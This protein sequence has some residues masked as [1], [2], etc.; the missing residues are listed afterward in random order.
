VGN[1]CESATFSSTCF[2]EVLLRA[3]NKGALGYIGGTNNTYWNEDFWWGVGV[4]PISATPTYNSTNLGAYDRKFHDM[5]GISRQDWYVAQGAMTVAGNL[6]VAQSGSSRTNYYWEIYTLLGDP[7]LVVWL[8]Q[9]DT[10][11]LTYSDPVQGDTELLVSTVSDALVAVKVNQNM[12]DVEIATSS[13]VFTL[14]MSQLSGGD[15]VI[16]TATHHEYYPVIDTIIIESNVDHVISLTEGWNGIS[17]YL[18]L[19]DSVTVNI[20]GQLA[21][22]LIIMKNMT[23]AYWPPYANNI[24][25]WKVNDGYLVKVTDDCILTLSG[26]PASGD[27]ISLFEGWNMIA[28]R[29]Q[30]PVDVVALFENCVENL[31]IVKATDGSGVYWPSVNINSIGSLQPGKAYMVKVEE[32]CLITF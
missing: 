24:P 16:I 21:D 13:S 2:G 32:D 30:Q 18:N 12:E 9:P 20:L 7:S 15:T 3:E 14:Y 11:P 26:V 31:I 29:S 4:E 8:S 6:A 17:T 28:V 23:S 25:Y 5:P 19:S 22:T 1:C 10:L 27:E